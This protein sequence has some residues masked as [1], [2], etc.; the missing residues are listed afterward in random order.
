MKGV[1]H[2]LS[3]H[4][5]FS[6][7]SIHI[8]YYLLAQAF[9]ILCPLLTAAR[10]N[11][12]PPSCAHP[13]LCCSPQTSVHRPRY[14]NSMTTSGRRFVAC[15]LELSVL[16]PST[17]YTYDTDAAHATSRPAYPHTSPF[18]SVVWLQPPQ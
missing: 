17:Q 8:V 13:L 1:Q 3:F 16:N 2:P 5:F 14:H 11:R 12:P 4:F 6:H 18:F 7:N 10:F 9:T 15:R